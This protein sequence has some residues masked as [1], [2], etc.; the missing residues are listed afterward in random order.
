VAGVVRGPDTGARGYGMAAGK[1][2]SAE[3]ARSRR[4]LLGAFGD[5]GHAFPTIALG[6]GLAARG[7]DVTLQTW[8]RWREHVEAEGLRFAAAPEY[9]VFPN[10]GVGSPPLDFYEAVVH[11]TRDTLPLVRKLAPEVVVAD[12]L[13]LAP[14]LAAELQGIPWATLI[15]HVHPHPPAGAP[16]YSIGARLP[17]S[18]LGRAFWRHA[19]RPV[20]HGLERGRR[21]LN[22]V[23]VRLGLPPLAHVHGGTSRE[24]ALVGTFPQLEYPRIWSAHTHVVGPLIWE[25]PTA[26]VELPP[27]EDP[28]V[29]IAPSTAQD[30]EHRLLRAALRGLADAPV[31]VIATWNRRLPPVPLPVPANAR[32]VEWLSYARTMPL[33]DVVVCHAGHGTL[34]RALSCGC[35]V[36]ACP[37]LGDMSENAARLEWAG[38]GVRLPRRFIAPRP[39]R[40]AVE[41]ALA[42]PAIRARA[43]ELAAWS[44]LHDPADTAAGLVEALGVGLEPTTLRLTAECSAN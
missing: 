39:L 19:T 7:H 32:V 4:I 27:G 20:E 44:V 16:I 11:A 21:D 36:V 1:S 33:C 25:P 13:T 3:G 2:R 43:Q 26:D 18:A 6:R 31:R 8:T 37:V 40:L 23:R 42:D 9:H 24:L 30:P 17:R 15:P 38:A 12:I 41:R 35:A 28:L 10:G 5:P 14:A 29:L 22:A 34:A